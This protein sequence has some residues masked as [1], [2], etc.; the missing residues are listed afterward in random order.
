MATKHIHRGLT[1][2][3]LRGIKSKIVVLVQ[4]VVHRQL[5][6]SLTLSAEDVGGGGVANQGVVFVGR[7]SVI[8]SVTAFDRGFEPFERVHLQLAAIRKGPIG[9]R[10]GVEL[11]VFVVGMLQVQVNHKVDLLADIAT[12]GDR[13]APTGH[14]ITGRNIITE[15][16]DG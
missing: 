3:R 13:S 1:H 11:F 5:Q 12:D 8:A 10:Q 15:P 2:I 16:G 14:D 4:D 9:Y 7:H 6:L